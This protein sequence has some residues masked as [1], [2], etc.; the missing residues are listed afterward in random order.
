MTFRRV[1]GGVLAAAVIVA[2]AFA[3]YYVINPAETRC[4]ALFDSPEDAR[5]AADD[6]VYA[7]F[8]NADVDER[9]NRTAVTFITG[10]TGS[11][12][13]QARKGFEGF[14]EMNQGRLGNPGDG[15]SER[16]ALG[17]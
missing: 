4:Y 16:E 9:D 14:I 8:D 1:F 17:G 10:D 11:D 3:L 2:G 13:A 6:A 5:A 7:G 15:C 12:V